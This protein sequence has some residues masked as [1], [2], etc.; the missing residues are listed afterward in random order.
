MKPLNEKL[1]IIRFRFTSRLLNK[2]HELNFK[3]R[4]RS[5]FKFYDKGLSTKRNGF[6][7]KKNT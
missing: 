7:F 6:S 4:H 2:R 3:C 1:S 5:R